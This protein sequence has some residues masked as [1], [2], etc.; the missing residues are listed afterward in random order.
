MPPSL[1]FLSNSRFICLPRPC[2]PK[3]L[4][5]ASQKDK[6]APILASRPFKPPLPNIKRIL[7]R[8]LYITKNNSLFCRYNFEP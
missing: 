2:Q 1:F 7:F 5:P 4:A 6:A 3:H 8:F